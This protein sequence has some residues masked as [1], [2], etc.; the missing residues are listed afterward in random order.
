VNVGGNPNF[1]LGMAGRMLPG[2]GDRAEP[3][4]QTLGSLSGGSDARFDHVRVPDRLQGRSVVLTVTAIAQDPSALDPIITVTDAEGREVSGVVAA[5]DAGTFVLRLSG[6]RVGGDCFVRV[7]AAPRLGK[8][9]RGNF[10]LAAD[11]STGPVPMAQPFA[12]GNL[13]SAAAE[14]YRSL[15]VG[16][17]ELFEF[18]LS[19]TAASGQTAQVQLLLY[20]DRGQLVYRQVAYA[21]QPASTGAIYLAA[22]GYTVRFVAVAPAGAP[23]P[24][25]SYALSGLV[26]SDPIGP[27]PINPT[28]SPTPAPSDAAPK[29]TDPTITTTDATTLV[30]DPTNSATVD[31]ADPS[32][33]DPPPPPAMPDPVPAQPT[34]YLWSAATRLPLSPL[35]PYA[36]GYVY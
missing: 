21:G 13:T 23:L 22:G 7:S 17:N 4:S 36:V 8:A 11:F 12:A 27:L 6:V 30:L 9:E 14:E 16:R 1:T 2:D 26:L 32:L 24:A 20:D 35:V 3:R 15:T 19:A 29:P 5:S 10:Y 34:D 31:F 28:T 18:T 25:V 33:T